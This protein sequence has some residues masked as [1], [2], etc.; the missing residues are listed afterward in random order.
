V[1]GR[2]RQRE[3]E[4]EREQELAQER[5][6]VERAQREHEVVWYLGLEREAPRMRFENVDYKAKKV[7]AR[8][9][10]MEEKERRAREGEWTEEEQEQEQEQE[11]GGAGGVSD[12][13]V[14]WRRES[15][16]SG[17]SWSL[18]SSYDVFKDESEFGFLGAAPL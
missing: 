16:A 12:E 13:G 1:K 14:V 3:R 2:R 8:A 17:R 6:E 7:A 4:Q 18:G 5:E 9:K 10:S 15:G 11:R